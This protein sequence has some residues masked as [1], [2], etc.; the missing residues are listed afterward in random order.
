MHNHHDYILW[1]GHSPPSLAHLGRDG[2][3]YEFCLSWVSDLPPRPKME[4]Q[5]CI[6]GLHCL[7]MN[8]LDGELEKRTVTYSS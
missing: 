4:K 6:S 5:A 7:K 3:D 8:D 1:D 2:V